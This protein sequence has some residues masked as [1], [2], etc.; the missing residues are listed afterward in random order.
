M[1]SE[2]SQFL[3]NIRYNSKLDYFDEREVISELRTHIEDKVQELTKELRGE[4]PH[5]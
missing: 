4:T 3:E 2:L 1:T 5:D